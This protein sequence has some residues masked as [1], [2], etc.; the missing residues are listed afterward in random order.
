MCLLVFIFILACPIWYMAMFRYFSTKQ[1]QLLSIILKHF[2]HQTVQTNS[3]ATQQNTGY[4]SAQCFWDMDLAVAHSLITSQSIIGKPVKQSIIPHQSNAW[5]ME[6]SVIVQEL[7][8]SN[9]CPKR[10]QYYLLRFLCTN[11]AHIS[12]QCCVKQSMWNSAGSAHFILLRDCEIS[13]TTKH[14]DR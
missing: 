2:F 8:P 13:N 14:T 12:I 3:K 6:G 4:I 9:L 10:N 5:R 1:S 11:T 7:S